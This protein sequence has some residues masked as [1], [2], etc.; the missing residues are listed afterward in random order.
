MNVNGQT[1]SLPMSALGK[2]ADGNSIVLSPTGQI[3]SMS[4]F[5]SPMMA[6]GAAGNDQFGDVSLL[7]PQAVTLGVPWTI[8]G[9][10]DPAEGKVSSTGILLAV[11]SPPGGDQI[12]HVR[13]RFSRTSSGS[14][15]PG[16]SSTVNSMNMSGLYLTRLDLNTG[17]ATHTTGTMHMTMSMTISMP[18]GSGATTPQT[19]NS[20]SDTTI[21]EDLM[22][23]SQAPAQTPS[24]S[25]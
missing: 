21:T 23:T 22:G 3:I 2:L 10:G 19:M 12:A 11:D 8:A 6:T 14:S 16:A 9:S 7:P 5:G 17:V 25:P 1:M 15:V 18:D 13:S 4:I 24:P 20:T